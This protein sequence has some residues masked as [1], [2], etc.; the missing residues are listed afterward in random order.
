MSPQSLDVRHDVRLSRFDPL[1]RI[2]M[3]D[4]FDEGLQGWTGL[5]GN[6]EGSLDT[7]LP[8][9]RDL[10]PPMLSN[11]TMWDTGSAGS[12]DGTYSMKLTTRPDPESLGVAVKRS[13]WRT[14]GELRMEAYVTFN[15]E[16]SELRLGDRDLRAFGF[17]F[18]LQDADK[19]VMP[20]LR[21]LNAR[22]GEAIQRW[23]FKREREPMADIGSSG[24][25]RSHFHLAD[26]GWEDVP[27]RHQPLCYNEIATK[28][29]WHYLRIGFDLK[30]MSFTE[31][32]CND[33]EYDVGTLAPMTMPAMPNL[34]CMLNL[35]FWVEADRDKRAFLHVDSI[36][37]SGD[38]A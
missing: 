6:Y 5:I 7:L 4:D 26:S 17:A 27:G 24:E 13:T 37:L 1:S 2:L 8:G 18:D 21:F 29:N 11:A 28:Q 25:M 20:H 23:Q 10:R 31:F 38:G 30:E 33:R 12:L 14:L 3:F 34:W 36:L 19:R 16:A 32:R 9:F 15:P 22:N 35:V